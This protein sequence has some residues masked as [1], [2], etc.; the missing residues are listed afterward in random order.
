MNLEKKC[1]FLERWENL[2]KKPWILEKMWSRKVCE[3]CKKKNQYFWTKMW[4]LDKN[5]NFNQK[6]ELQTKMW[7]LTKDVNFEKKIENWTYGNL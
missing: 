6:C 7:I 5:V 3:F 2:K 1:E 4:I